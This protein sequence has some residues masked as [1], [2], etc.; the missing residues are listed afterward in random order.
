MKSKHK[1]TTEQP[2]ET[3][4]PGQAEPFPGSSSR[5][6]DSAA[7]Q[8]ARWTLML[9]GCAFLTLLVLCFWDLF[10]ALLFR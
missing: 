4:M 1:P 9:W 8:G 7:D 10:R 2:P 3:D 6:G 5:A